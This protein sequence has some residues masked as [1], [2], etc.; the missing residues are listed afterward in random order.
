MQIFQRYEFFF[1][2]SINFDQLFIKLFFF[3]F[4]FFLRRLIQR[5]VKNSGCQ[6]RLVFLVEDDDQRAYLPSGLL[7]YKA[8]KSIFFFSNIRYLLLIQLTNIFTI[9]HHFRSLDVG[10]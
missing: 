5:I 3:C 10:A 1:H 6:E 8:T 4:F 7:L 9:F 2:F